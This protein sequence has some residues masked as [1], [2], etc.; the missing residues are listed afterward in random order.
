MI[1]SLVFQHL[2]HSLHK[3]CI[4]RSKKMWSFNNRHFKQPGH[5][6]KSN[7]D[8]NVI[9]D[10]GAEVI[11]GSTRLTAGTSQKICLNIISSLVMTKLGK[12]KNGRND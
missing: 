8:I 10:T 12:V 3:C 4:K 5:K 1:L 9:L 2:E 6:I 7:S 11:A